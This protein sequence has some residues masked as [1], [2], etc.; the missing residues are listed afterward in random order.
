M[1]LYDR[2]RALSTDS[3]EQKTRIERY[4]ALL[5]EL[6]QGDTAALKALLMHVV[7]SEE[8]ALV[9]SRQVLLEFAAALPSLPADSL[10]DVGGF[11]LEQIQ[12]RVT[13]FEEQASLIR[14]H[15]A[16]VYE[17]E[18]E[19]ASAV[20]AALDYPRSLTQRARNC[21]IERGARGACVVPSGEDA[22]G[23]PAGLGDPRP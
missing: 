7:T 1:D 9:V 10:K 6:L 4:K 16:D 21:A 22:G 19:W 20:R 18:E 15:L 17:R 8:V 3:V 2:L 11:V 14:E 12:P 23:H 5:V 13:S